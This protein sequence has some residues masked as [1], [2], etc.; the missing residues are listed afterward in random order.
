MARR[1]PE[2]EWRNENP[3]PPPP[4]GQ[5]VATMVVFSFLPALL[6]FVLDTDP[7]QDYLKDTILMTLPLTLGAGVASLL[8]GLWLL[9]GFCKFWEL[10][11]LIALIMAGAGYLGVIS[12]GQFGAFM[13]SYEQWIPS[14]SLLRIVGYSLLSVVGFYEIYGPL[15][16]FSA[17]LIG[18]IAPW[19]GY[20][21][22]V[23]WYRHAQNHLD[24]SN[25]SESK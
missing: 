14:H 21:K 23:E 6:V 17:L 1:K 7:V 10:L 11:L 18:A 5:V 19:L 4:V 13:A 3:R 25:S 12:S 22:L 9:G 24:E 2:D 16:F 8:V 20:A 15:R